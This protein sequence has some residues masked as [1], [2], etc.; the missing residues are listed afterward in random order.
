MLVGIELGRAFTHWRRKQWYAPGLAVWWLASGTAT[1]V[2]VGAYQSGYNHALDFFPP[3]VLAAGVLTAGAIEAAGRIGKD[4]WQ[5][6]GVAVGIAGIFAWQS[7]SYPGSNLYYSPGSMPAANRAAML[8]GLV[9]QIEGTPGDV[10]S[11][12]IYLQLKTNRPVVYDDLYHQQLQAHAGQWDESQFIADLRSRRFALVLLNIGSHRFTE[13]GWEALNANY[14]LIFPDGIG[15]WRP[16]P[17]PLLPQFAFDNYIFGSAFRLDGVSYER[18][19]GSILTVSSYW[20]VQQKLPKNYTLFVH[21]LDANGQLIAQQ[22]A[23][24][25]GQVIP[26]PHQ[27]VRQGLDFGPFNPQTLATSSWQA[28]EWLLISQSLPLPSGL[29]LRQGHYRL[30]IGMYATKPDGSLEALPISYKGNEKAE[31]VLP[32]L[33]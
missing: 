12:D 25:N 17:Q 9:K 4:S 27:L 22:D 21:L 14:Q 20:Q 24:P 16:R 15:L 7:L 6:I 3:L 5:R 2:T 18:Q 11:E 19:T 31:L 29:D 26:D 23:P 10:L 30:E 33:Q 32:A 13:A 8:Q 28:G 1:L